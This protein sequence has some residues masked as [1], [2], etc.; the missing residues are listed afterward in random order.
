[1]DD[2]IPEPLQGRLTL[3]EMHAAFQD[4]LQGVAYAIAQLRYTRSGSM[5]PEDFQ[6]LI[7]RALRS[8]MLASSSDPSD[9]YHEFLRILLEDVGKFVAFYSPS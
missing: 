7:Q 6:E 3:T 4:F 8:E 1:M 2:S 9:A 5:T